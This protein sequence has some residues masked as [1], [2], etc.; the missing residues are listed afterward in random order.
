LPPCVP[1]CPRS[2]RCASWP[3]RCASGGLTMWPTSSGD[4]VLVGKERTLF[5]HAAATRLD[6]L[7]DEAGEE[8]DAGCAW[9]TGVAVFDALEPQD[10]IVLVRDVVL[11]L[12]DPAVPIPKLTAANEAAVHAV[13]R[14]L[15]G[16]VEAEI[17]CAGSCQGQE[18]KLDAPS[19]VL[20]DDPLY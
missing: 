12:T 10:R 4:R 3:A 11:A 5:V 2:A 6:Y 19:F 14:S 20:G 18:P 1:T 7:L 13:F 8:A 15:R 9:H 16:E 17:D